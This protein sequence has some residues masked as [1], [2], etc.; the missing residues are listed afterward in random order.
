MILR[1]KLDGLEESRLKAR[2]IMAYQIVQELVKVAG[3]QFV[4]T[5]P[6]TR[7]HDS[8]IPW[9]LQLNNLLCYTDFSMPQTL[10]LPSILDGISISFSFTLSLVFTDIST[11]I[12][13]CIS[14]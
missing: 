9:Y 1:L 12:N 11:R 2:V 5:I 6:S 10:E 7:G 8:E 14:K 4:P 13:N 3:D